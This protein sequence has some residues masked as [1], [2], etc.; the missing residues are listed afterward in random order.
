MHTPLQTFFCPAA[1]LVTL[2]LLLGS[3]GLSVV[4]NV[5][6]PWL[7]TLTRYTSNVQALVAHQGQLS[8]FCGEAQT[9]RQ[10]AIAFCMGI[11]IIAAGRQQRLFLPCCRDVVR[12]LHFD[13]AGFLSDLTP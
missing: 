7:Q 9:G 3:V 11:S 8:A 13:S 1:R 6:L 4:L 12:H 10:I 2:L 5:F